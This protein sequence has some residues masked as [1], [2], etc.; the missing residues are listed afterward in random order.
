MSNYHSSITELLS[1]QKDLLEKRETWLKSLLLMSSTLFG[2]L[3]SLHDKTSNNPIDHLLFACSL[4]L[5]GLG[6]LLTTIALYSQIELLSLFA[7]AYKNEI[8]SA[9]GERRDVKPVIVNTCKV[10]LICEKVGYICF[11][12]SV[13]LLIVYSFYPSGV[14]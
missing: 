9:Q 10:F 4:A 3:I 12:F 11:S 6:I 2:I 8:L 1:T 14:L 7:K 13:L 5:I